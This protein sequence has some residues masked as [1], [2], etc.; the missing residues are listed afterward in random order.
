MASQ[1]VVEPEI[2]IASLRPGR[3]DQSMVGRLL[4]F[5]YSKNVKKH[6]EFMGIT[7]LLL[8]DKDSL[9]HGFI[10]AARSAYYRPF[11]KEGVVVR[12]SQFEVAKCAKT[13][14][15]ID[16]PFL[17]RFIPQTTIVEIVENVPAIGLRN[18]CC[19]HTIRCSDLTDDGVTSRVVVRLLIE[20]Q[21]IV[22]MSLW[23]DVASVFKGILKTG[24]KSQSVMVVTT[25]D[26]KL[27]GGNL[28]LNSTPATKFYFDPKIKAVSLFA[29]SLGEQHQTVFKCNDTKEG[30]KKKEVVTIGELH[31]FITN[32]D[33]QETD[34]IC[35]ARVV[36]VLQ[37][38]GWTFL[39][40]T[41]CSKKLEKIGNALRC[42]RCVNPNITG[43]IKYRVEL[44][45]CDGFD[46]ATFV[47]FDRE[48][49]KLT[50]QGAA[51]LSLGQVNI[52]ED[53]ELPHCVKILAGQ[54]FVYQ[55][56]VTPFNFTPNHRTFTVSAIT[57]NIPLR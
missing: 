13:Y 35:K 32:S 55:I 30:I 19:A 53:E 25:L 57:E 20:P 27:F 54:E 33:E 15:I 29:A 17:L 9:I 14:K 39:S 47:V 56:R 43:I 12:I 22:N 28:Y 6:G 46:N 41:S 4:R 49:V 8:G 2:A 24:D 45:V 7:L 18:S 3:S 52:G 31:N 10:T 26:P 11:L 16:H 5:W 48:K 21:V 36:E 37:Q 40:C 42:T 44:S 50:K 1:S 34:F 38:N 23:D 51:K